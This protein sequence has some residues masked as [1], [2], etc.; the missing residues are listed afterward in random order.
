MQVAQCY[1]TA[2][3]AN[4]YQ[5]YTVDAFDRWHGAGTSNTMPRL[6][7]G[8]TNEQWISTRYVQDADYFRIQNVTLGYDFGRFL[9]SNSPFEKFR[10]YVQAQNLYTFTGYTGVDPEVGSSGGKW[11]WARGI[12]VGLYPQARTFLAGAS[13]TFKD[14]KASKP[15]PAIVPQTRIEYVTD[16]T[17]IDRLNGEINKLRA[18][19]ERLKN[20][21]PVNTNT[22]ITN[23]KVITYPYFVNFEIA[24]T[25][26]V[27]RERVNLS[28]IA[29]M[30]RQNPG[31]KYS[32]MGYADKATGSAERNEWLAENRA[33]NVYDMLVNEYGVPASSL[34]LD[35]KG[36]VE[37]L[38]FNDPQMSR[39]VIISEIK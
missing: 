13:I 14:K 4:P 38:Y 39:S 3:L 19:N 7:V 17:E 37:N 20:Q 6:S 34:V 12:D 8:S 9:K 27:N 24:K 22:V 10:I 11:N 36:G 15:A 5:N 21:Q 1:R 30:I 33:K 31:K 28:T 16:N 2:L 18:D 23:E 25:E 32:V 35:S 29:Q 26:I